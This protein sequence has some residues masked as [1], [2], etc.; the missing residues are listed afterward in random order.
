MMMMMMNRRMM[1]LTMIQ[2]FHLKKHHDQLE[3]RDY[4]QMMMTNIAL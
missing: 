3:V 1:N 2:S 4:I